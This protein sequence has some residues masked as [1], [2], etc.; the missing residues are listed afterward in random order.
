MV[1]SL[2]PRLQFREMSL[3]GGFVYAVHARANGHHACNPRRIVRPVLHAD[4]NPIPSL[5]VV[6]DV[7]KSLCWRPAELCTGHVIAPR[8][9]ASMRMMEYRT[10]GMARSNARGVCMPPLSPPTQVLV[11]GSSNVI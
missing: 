2:M 5:P 11:D 4:L 10:Y 3:H 1:P 6:S 9:I 8:R 7:F